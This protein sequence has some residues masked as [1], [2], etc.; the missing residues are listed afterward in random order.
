MPAWR[1]FRGL[2]TIPM[3]PGKMITLTRGTPYTW[4]EKSLP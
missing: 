1:D 3:L 4:Q 2:Q